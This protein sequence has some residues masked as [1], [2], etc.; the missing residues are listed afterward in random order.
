METTLLLRGLAIGFAIA[1]PVGPIG[2]LCIRQSLAFGWLRGFVAGLGAATADALYGFVAGFGL[3]FITSF[4]IEQQ[5]WLRLVGG[6]FLC[7]LGV[8]TFTSIP[9]QA[10]ASAKDRSLAGVYTSTF[11]LTLTNP[12]TI[13]AFAAIF[14]GLGLASMEQNYFSALLLV[15]GVFCGSAFWW[16]LLSGSVSLV[17]AKLNLV[18][19]K[20]VNRLSGIVI[21]AFGIVAL[22]K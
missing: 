5:I 7:Y 20:W 9:A 19:L 11:A 2:I 21:T 16:L 12:A 8:K 22:L 14:S 6:A 15:V 10:A 3:T 4:L 1:A 18:D 17:Q 13:L